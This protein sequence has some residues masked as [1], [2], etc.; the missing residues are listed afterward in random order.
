MLHKCCCLFYSFLT[1]ST[2]S[3]CVSSSYQISSNT[4]LIKRRAGVTEVGEHSYN[5]GWNSMLLYTETWTYST[6]SQGFE[7]RV[8]LISG[9]DIHDNDHLEIPESHSK[10][11]Q[12]HLTVHFFLTNSLRKCAKFDFGS[13]SVIGFS[14]RARSLASWSNKEWEYTVINQSA[15]VHSASICSVK[16]VK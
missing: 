8:N 4:G 1:S 10:W 3:S 6:V 7:L 15:A 13:F 14:L 2:D 16:N 11:Q 12:W 9:S 5:H